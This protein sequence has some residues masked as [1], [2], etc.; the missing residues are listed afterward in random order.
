MLCE[1]RGKD[2]D[3]LWTVAG[4][5]AGGAGT[6]AR[7]TGAVVAG[8]ELLA[9]VDELKLLG[10]ADELAG[11]SPLGAGVVSTLLPLGAGVVIT[12]G[13]AALE[14]AS[15]AADSDLRLTSLTEGRLMLLSKGILLPSDVTKE[16]TS[17]KR[18]S[19]FCSRHI[20]FTDSSV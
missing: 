20:C 19:I 4:A 12:A 10:C 5:L 3:A 15:D 16:L 1:P 9:C 8:V 7:V 18:E 11:V 6:C 13:S 14:I 17:A 2:A